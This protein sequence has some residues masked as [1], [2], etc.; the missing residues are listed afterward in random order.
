LS[1]IDHDP[2]FVINRHVA[3]FGTQ[4]DIA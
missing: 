1:C 2:V 3:H 4:A